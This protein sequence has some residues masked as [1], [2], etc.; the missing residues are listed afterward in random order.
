MLLLLLLT[1]GP[2]DLAPRPQ[3]DASIYLKVAAEYRTGDREGALIEI[4]GWRGGEIRAAIRALREETNRGHKVV[5]RAGEVVDLPVEIDFR[6]VEAA[7]L[8][9]VEAGLLE[10]QSLGVARAESQFAAATSLV[11]WSHELKE[12]RLRLLARLRRTHEATKQ[13]DRALSITLKIDRREFYVALAAATLAVGFPRMALPFAERAKAAAPLDAEALL[14]SACVK[15]S[16]A[17][18]EKVRTREGEARRL[19][20]EAEALFRQ[21][22]SADPAQNEAHLRLGRVLLAQSRPHEAEPVLQQAAEQARDNPQRYLALLF[23]GRA[24]ELQDKPNRGA[25]FYRRALEAWPESQAARL[26]LARCLEASAG[27]TA[28]RPHVMASLLDSS[29]PAREPDPWW[30]YPFGPRGLAKVA[31]ERLWQATL[32]RSFGS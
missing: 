12:Q 30:S 4:R 14:L 23:L 19:G 20:E 16:L 3:N 9:H 13:L 11:E 32:G 17:L 7:A 18:E 29:K 5:L 10:L 27:P 24:S 28:A 25:T 15:E 31:V 8:M 2:P 6:T 22:L 26:A 21:A 1:V